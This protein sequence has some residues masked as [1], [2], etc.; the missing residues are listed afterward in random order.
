MLENRHLTVELFF[1]NERDIYVKQQLLQTWAN[2]AEILFMA[3][4]FKTVIRVF[5]NT[6]SDSQIHSGKLLQPKLQ[7]LQL[8]LYINHKNEKHFEVVFSTLSLNNNDM[9]NKSD[10]V[11]SLMKNSVQ[12]E[13]LR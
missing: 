8:K 13:L 4:L 10:T 2:E 11:E 1:I 5:S 12:M 6:A 7:I 3:Y 9:N